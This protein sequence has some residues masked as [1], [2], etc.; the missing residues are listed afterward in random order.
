MTS[1]E[2]EG[3]RANKG[4]RFAGGSPKAEELP[5]QEGALRVS[6]P[7]FKFW[8]EE[9]RLILQVRSPYFEAEEKVSDT[10]A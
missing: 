8:P 6:S 7:F 1:G 2:G 9:S 5:V 3:G 10:H 4:Q